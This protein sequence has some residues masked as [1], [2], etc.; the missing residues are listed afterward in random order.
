MEID[1]LP[2]LLAYSVVTSPVRADARTL[3]DPQLRPIEVV[4]NARGRFRRLVGCGGKLPLVFRNAV[5]RRSLG[6]LRPRPLR[7]PSV[8][9]IPVH[10]PSLRIRG[11]LVLSRYGCCSTVVT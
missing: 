10:T 8:T 3:G 4:D 1:E 11:T 2:D 5:P 7:T 9:E 6:P